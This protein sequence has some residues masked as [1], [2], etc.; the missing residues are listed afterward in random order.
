MPLHKLWITA[1]ADYN[2]R[3]WDILFNEKE[4]PGKELFILHAHMKQITEIVE[5]N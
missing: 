2:I 5:L 1:G 4:V 3:G